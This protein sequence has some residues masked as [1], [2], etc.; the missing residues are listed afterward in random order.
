VV[1]IE[2]F[3]RER[4][5]AWRELESLVEAAKGRPERLGPERVRRLGSLY[6]SSAADLAAARRRFGTDHT[7]LRLEQLVGRA[8]GLV[9]DSESRRGSL[10]T[11]FGRTYWQRIRERPLVLAV[12][13]LL[14]FGPAI[15]SLVWALHDPGSASG[16]VPSAFRAVTEPRH[17]TNLGLG[18]NRSSLMA[19][20]IFTNNI[21]VTLL[22]F[23]G[24]MTLGL[25]TMSLLIF[26]GVLLGTLFGLAWGAGNGRPFVELVTAHGV[27]ELSCIVVAGTAGLRL[28]WAIVAPGYRRRSVVLQEEARRTVEL[29]LGTA[30]WLVLA[31]LVEGFITPAGYGLGAD[32]AVGFGL[33]ALFWGLVLLRGGRAPSA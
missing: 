32:L 13:A 21:R 5:P 8:R 4:E 19:T 29:A 26:N 25:L 2:R 6:R 23:A 17:T 15:L 9:Y 30:P 14:L 1:T 16:L 27:L 28:G 31:G 20:Q 18:P 11:F 12:A 22:A 33:G 7:V 24:G 10:R 3:I